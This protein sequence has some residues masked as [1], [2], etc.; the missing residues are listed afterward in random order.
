VTGSNEARAACGGLLVI[1][2]FCATFSGCAPPTPT[3][4]DRFEVTIQVAPDGTADIDER[5]TIPADRVTGS[6]ERVVAPGR[7]D[8]LEFVS[9]SID[10]TTASSAA[11]TVDP[12]GQVFRVA[13]RLDHT[14]VPRILGL[15]Y[16]ATGVL[17]VFGRRGQFEWPAIPIARTY[18]IAAAR[19]D[20][21]VP[22]G[23]VRLGAWGLAEAGWQV[24][25]L[26]NGIAAERGAVPPDQGA[27]VLAEMAVDPA[28]IA[29][30]R[31]QHDAALGRQL[32][33]AFISGGLFILTIGAGVVWLIRFEASS[34]ARESAGQSS[35]EQSRTT[36]GLYVAGLVCL[37]F[38]LALA[39]V[40]HL[41]LSRYGAWSMAI[42]GG[43]LLVG[44]LFVL[45]GK[46]P[47]R[48]S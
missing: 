43:V 45:T 37:I 6:F 1:A 40:T 27:T 7:L 19:L 28:R 39:V 11:V 32:V 42:P 8:G 24:T 16:R 33:P 38:G 10:G 44:L 3:V 31:W 48:R 30:P 2:G 18:P 14:D 34:H 26:P 20:L 36:E 47:L 12:S 35:G 29:E 13:W 4:V 21:T 41:T 17:G 5:I 25:A 23:V 22:P 15:R 46:R 9:V